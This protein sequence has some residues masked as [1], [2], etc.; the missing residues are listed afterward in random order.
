M[1]IISL[2]IRLELLSLIEFVFQKK[3]LVHSHN[4]SAPPCS[5]SD[6]DDR[7]RNDRR[8]FRPAEHSNFMGRLCFLWLAPGHLA[9]SCAQD[10][11]C[12]ACFKYGHLS[13]FSRS[14]PRGFTGPLHPKVSRLS[15]QLLQVLLLLPLSP[16]TET[17]PL[18][19]GNH[20]NL[21]FIPPFIASSVAS[22]PQVSPP[23]MENFTID[24]HPHV[25]QG[26]KWSLGILRLHCLVSTPTLGE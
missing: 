6:R 4:M 18:P 3:R 7:V 17:F 1:R 5:S 19:W 22:F 9:T 12:R 23:S 2:H 25:P 21:P 26:L 16:F 20:Q 10:I 8:E 13:C 11:R 24:P 15:L 14:F